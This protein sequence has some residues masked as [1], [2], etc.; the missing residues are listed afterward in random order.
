M[1]S[2]LLFTYVLVVTFVLVVYAL[3]LWAAHRR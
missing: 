2:D 1:I 3:I